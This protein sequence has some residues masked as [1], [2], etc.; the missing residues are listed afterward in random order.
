MRISDAELKAAIAA[1]LATVVPE[2]DSDALAERVVSVLANREDRPAEPALLT[3]NGRVLMD[4]VTHPDTSLQQ[5]GDRLGLTS[6]NVGHAMTRLVAAGW[7]VR[8]R[9]G[10]QNAYTF[11]PETVLAHRDSVLFLRGLALLAAQR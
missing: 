1:A 8:T 3:L 9:V 4:L 5:A 2:Q 10:R 6:A 7:G 11:T